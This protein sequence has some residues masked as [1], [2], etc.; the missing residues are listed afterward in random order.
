MDVAWGFRGK[1]RSSKEPCW[2][3]QGLPGDRC[4]AEQRLCPTQG[5]G[6]NLQW[7]VSDLLAISTGEAVRAVSGLCNPKHTGLA[8]AD[9][10]PDSSTYGRGAVD[11]CPGSSELKVHGLSM[12]GYKLPGHQGSG[13]MR[14]RTANSFLENA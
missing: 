5:A 9:R 11:A 12:L 2:G 1:E 6:A 7:R 14:G 3:I 4:V 13:S 8:S 10:A